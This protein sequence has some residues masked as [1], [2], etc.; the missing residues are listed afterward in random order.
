MTVC[1]EG[2][3]F[4]HLQQEVRRALDMRHRSGEGP[5]SCLS[6]WLLLAGLGANHRGA[7]KRDLSVRTLRRPDESRRSRL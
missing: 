3:Y 7:V 6:V 5:G 1:R 2:F 4:K